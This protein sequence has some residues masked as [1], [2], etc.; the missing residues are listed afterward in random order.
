M[1]TDPLISK[2]TQ[3][4]MR[5]RIYNQ[6]FPTGYSIKFKSYNTLVPNRANLWKCEH[7][8]RIMLNLELFNTV[9]Y[10]T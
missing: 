5:A 7:Y 8:H 10:T 2:C 9:W 3:T 1:Y 4:L 6:L